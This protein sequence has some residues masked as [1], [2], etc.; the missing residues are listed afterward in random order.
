MLIWKEWK[1]ISAIKYLLKKTLAKRRNIANTAFE[2]Q[3]FESLTLK[4][5]KHYKMLSI[6]FHKE[7]LVLYLS[8]K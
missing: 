3:R 4:M 6:S 5:L 8:N 1:N 2:Y 7:I